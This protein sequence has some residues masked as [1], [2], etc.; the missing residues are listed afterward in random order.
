MGGIMRALVL[1]ALV[2]A[3]GIQASQAANTGP[4]VL[5]R[6]KAGV[7]APQPVH[8]CKSKSLPQVPNQLPFGPGESL[9]YTVSVAGAPAGQVDISLHERALH[10]GRLVFP[11]VVRAR[12]HPV[13]SLWT[14]MESELATLVDPEG[15]VPV[16]MKSL[17]HGDKFT[18]TENVQFLHGGRQV[19]VQTRLDGKAWNT[20]LAPRGDALDALSLVYYARSRELSVGAPFCFEVYQSR[21]L[22]RVIGTVGGREMVETDAGSFDAW[23]ASG[24]AH[25]LG[26][27]GK[28]AQAREYTAWMTADADRIPVLLRTPTPMGD[29][30]VRLVRFEQGRRLARGQTDPAGPG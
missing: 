14:K 7:V 2:T 4:R 30:V 18:Y 20:T 3:V 17:T 8:P 15:V 11:A 1:V 13:L 19:D 9:S 24:I 23:V 27:V 16:N 21:T 29:A 28:A 6:E 10:E 26:R 12:S 22:W 5:A 25:P